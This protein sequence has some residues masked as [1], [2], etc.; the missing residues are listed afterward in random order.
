MAQ[1]P[2]AGPPHGNKALDM[3]SYVL[4][5][6]GVDGWAMARHTE[7]WNQVV[8]VGACSFVAFSSVAVSGGSN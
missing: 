2:P 5:C 1:C 8:S 7:S 6:R 4:L 3:F